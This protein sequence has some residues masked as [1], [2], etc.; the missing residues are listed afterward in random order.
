M[1]TTY[2][3][4]TFGQKV[5]KHL[6]EE[7]KLIISENM[8]LY[9]IGLH[10][11]D[12]LFYYKPLKVNRINEKGNE[13]HGRNAD[14]FFLS[15]RDI[16]KGC[17]DF[18]PPC[19]YIMGFIC[20]YMMD[21]EC[22][23]YIREKEKSGFSHNEIETRFDKALIE[24][25]GLSLA[26]YNPTPHIIPDMD[27][28]SRISMFYEGISSDEVL[29]ALNSMKFYLKLVSVSGRIRLGLLSLALRLSGKYNSLGGLL[30]NRG[31]KQD[32]GEINGK[33]IE[34]YEN[35]IIL[36]A[37]TVNEYYRNIFKDEPI[38]SRLCR[39]FG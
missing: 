24:R 37:G 7:I 30:L 32:F 33:L 17:D 39:N 36:T 12:I 11:P 1:P 34:L 38:S 16:I 21:T 26:S 23:P 10:G 29:K 20:H 28:A 13:I 2:A 18:R 14:E 3:H 9:N 19:A 25:D 31:T 8:D 6:D 27:Y 22:H 15:A 35:A 4:Y 5:F